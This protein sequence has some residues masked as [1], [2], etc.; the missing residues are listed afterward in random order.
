MSKNKKFILRLKLCG[1]A[2][3]VSAQVKVSEQNKLKIWFDL[4][5]AGRSLWNG[6]MK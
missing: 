2:R 3:A 5:K 1:S 4:N 6:S